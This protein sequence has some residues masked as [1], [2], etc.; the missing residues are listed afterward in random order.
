MVRARD[1]TEEEFETL[2]QHPE[3]SDEELSEFLNR[4]PGAVAAV[5]DFIHS[6]HNGGSIS[7][8]SQMMAQRLRKGGWT[9]PRCG[10]VFP[11]GTDPRGN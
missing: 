4:T 9:C 2:L 10:K 7:G 6:Y 5:R 8:L 1:W 11:L 3:M